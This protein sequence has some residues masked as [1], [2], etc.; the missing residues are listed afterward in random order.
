[1]KETTSS[2][3][4]NVKVMYGAQII[5]WASSFI[6]MLFLPRYL[7]AA[8]YGVLY[9]AISL[10]ALG[11]LLIDLGLSS[12]FVK[13][14]ARDH[15]KVNLFFMN[16]VS[17]RVVT[18]VI[19]MAGMVLY[20]GFMNYSSEML[21]L[22][23]ILGFGKLL[24][25]VSDL[26]HRIFQSHERLI[27]RSIAMVIERIA[28]AVITVTMLLAGYGVVTVALVMTLSVLLNFL[29]SLFFLPRLVTLKV[30]I[31]PSSWGGLFLGGLPFLISTFF[32]FV[33]Y[34]IDVVML[35]AMTN[36][37]VVGW[38]GAPYKLFDALMFFPSILQIAIFPVVSRLWQDSR[39]RFFLTARRALDVSV[40]VAIPISF[41]MVLVARPI[42]GLFFGLEDY[43]RSVLL[44]QG[45]AICLPLVYANFVISTVNVSSDRQKEI[46]VI[47]IAAA[48]VN[49]GLNL[50]LIPVY[51]NSSANGAIGAV[52][53]TIVTECFVMVMFIRL[54]P[55]GCF[56]RDNVILTGKALLA[57]L[58]AGTVLWSV[59]SLLH[60][61]YV[62]GMV[63][64]IAYAG[65]LI[66]ADVLTPRDWN[67]L[68]SFIP[69]RRSP[70]L[71]QGS[72]PATQQPQ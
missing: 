12:Y 41:C 52:I 70:A 53:A 60:L 72:E 49:I 5:T 68:M 25:A 30:H 64:V 7:G 71:P 63:G 45:L 34:R 66:A 33:Y 43:E 10:T 55:R 9:F 48:V 2:I 59:E 23:M 58:I 47:S 46:S 67:A 40:I 42:V 54:L 19:V 26:A 11:G 8:G 16:S 13:E 29:T 31:N 28:L 57:G 37:S 62:S 21:A 1:M 32:S 65:L 20:V 14:V 4:T 50:W 15:S 22:L 39:E 51:Q 3:L 18:W 6:L 56:G 69:W 35:S 27:Y 24:E 17:L 61:W 36:D 38:Y 44:L